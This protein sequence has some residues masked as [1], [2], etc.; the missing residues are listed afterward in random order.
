[1]VSSHLSSQ[2]I[3][4]AELKAIVYELLTTVEELYEQ[5]GYHGSTEKFFSLVEKCADKRPVSCL[6]FH[7]SMPSLSGALLLLIML[8]YVCLCVV[9][10]ISAYPHLIQGPVYPACQGRLDS[11]PS[12]PY[13]EILQVGWK[14]R[15]WRSYSTSQRS[16][17]VALCVPLCSSSPS[18]LCCIVIWPLRYLTVSLKGMRLAVWY[19]SKFFI[20]CPSFSVPTDSSTRSVN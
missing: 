13:G 10:R 17:S 5:N 12:S 9:G 3:G 1:M 8:V 19:G 15:R 14:H 16:R 2:T 7:T 6:S 18:H 11:E 4:S 20:S